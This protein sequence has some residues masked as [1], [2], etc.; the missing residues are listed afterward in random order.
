MQIDEFFWNYFEKT[1]TINAYLM[2]KNYYEEKEAPLLAVN[3]E[4]I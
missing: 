1:G 3:E 2:Y 4:N